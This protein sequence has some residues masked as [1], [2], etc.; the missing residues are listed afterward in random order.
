MRLALNVTSATLYVVAA[1][2]WWRAPQT[3]PPPGVT[4]DGSIGRAFGDW[5]RAG[6]RTNRRAALCTGV[7]GFATRRGWLL[8]LG[9]DARVDPVSVSV[10]F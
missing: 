9:S 6:A 7:A 10:G 3:P 8:A 2:L 1:W 4:A 5:V